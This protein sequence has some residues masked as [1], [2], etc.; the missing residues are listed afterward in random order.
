[1]KGNLFCYEILNLTDVYLKNS[2]SN[3]V[4]EAINKAKNLITSPTLINR[5]LSKLGL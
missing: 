3:D 2:I 1:M 4:L 5:I